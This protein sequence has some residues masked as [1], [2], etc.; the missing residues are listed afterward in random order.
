MVE[1]RFKN[2]ATTRLH[3]VTPLKTNKVLL[4]PTYLGWRTSKVKVGGMPPEI[5]TAWLVD[6]IFLGLEEE[7]VVLQATYMAHKK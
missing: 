3:S 6:A 1:V 7:M 4:L 5:N 2:A